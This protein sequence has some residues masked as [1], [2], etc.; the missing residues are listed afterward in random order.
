LN[1]QSS[2]EVPDTLPK[3]K[4]PV[5][6]F[7]IGG[8][9]VFAA[10]ILLA[11]TSLRGNTQYYLTINELLSHSNGQTQNVRISGVVLGDTIHYDVSSNTLTFT[12]ANIP[13]DNATIEKMGGLAQALHISAIDPNAK[14][15]KIKYQG[16]KPD[17]LTN[18]AQAIMTGSLG[19]DGVFTV[20][21]LLLKCPSRYDD[22]LPAQAG[23]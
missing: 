6:K 12:V 8:L 13:G 5:N 21:E 11:V 10:V 17:L 18:E 16:S 20:S 14:Q 15:L 23:S 1:A 22:S 19:S 2:Q 9:F 7:F 3:K 4:P